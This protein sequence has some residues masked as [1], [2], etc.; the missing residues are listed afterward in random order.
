MMFCSTG[1]GYLDA[2][3]AALAN[4]FVRSAGVDDLRRAAALE[5]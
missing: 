2:V 4:D 5:Q 1:G 3:S